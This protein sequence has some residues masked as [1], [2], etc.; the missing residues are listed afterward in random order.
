M[1]R[2]IAAVILWMLLN[3]LWFAAVVWTIATVLKWMGVA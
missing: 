3:M 2:V 1:T